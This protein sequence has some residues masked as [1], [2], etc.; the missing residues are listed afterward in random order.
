M[1]CSY[2]FI[3]KAIYNVVPPVCVQEA[4][5]IK[6]AP[7]CPR[8]FQEGIDNGEIVWLGSKPYGICADCTPQEVSA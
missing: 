5:G 4:A 8:C 6:N 3:Q 7:L 2:C 1:N